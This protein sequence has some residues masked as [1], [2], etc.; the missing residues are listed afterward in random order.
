M[1]GAG[2]LHSI[3]GR[4]SVHSCKAMS[5]T[6]SG[7]LSR[8]GRS[9]ERITTSKLF[10]SSRKAPE[11]KLATTKGHKVRIKSNQ[12]IISSCL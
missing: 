12:S 5:S 7:S 11:T 8:F 3:S 9:C 1:G 6:M 2:L 4:G 10:I